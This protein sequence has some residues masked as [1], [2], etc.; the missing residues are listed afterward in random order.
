VIIKGKRTWSLENI[1]TDFSDSDSDG[2]DGVDE[3][4][5]GEEVQSLRHIL[6]EE[7]LKTK[8]VA[9]APELSYL[10]FFHSMAFKNWETSLAAPCHHMHSGSES[11]PYKLSKGSQRN[12]CIKFNRDHMMRAYPS[13]SRV[14]SSN[15]NPLFA[16]SVGYQLVALNIQNS[17]SS[18]YIND[19]RFREN[20]ACGYILKPN[21]LRTLEDVE[22]LPLTLTVRI[23]G[24]SCLPKPKEAIKGEC[25]DSYVKVELFDVDQEIGRELSKSYSTDVFPNNGFCPIWVHNTFQFTVKNENVAMLHLTVMDKDRGVADDFIANAAIPISCLRKG[26]RS[27]RLFDTN[28]TRS[29]AFD[30]ASLLVHI[31]IEMVV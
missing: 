9:L 18:L 28:N 16:W 11:K 21:E 29:G 31:E 30:F 12:E 19:G 1:E 2:E 7:K 8:N 10:T 5:F 25:I 17:D 4:I 15:Y 14:N 24:G 13:G 6:K 3:E 20:G 27:V 22:N 26:Y 23:L